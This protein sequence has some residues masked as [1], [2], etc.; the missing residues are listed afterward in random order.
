MAFE[1]SRMKLDSAR[2]DSRLSDSHRHWSAC[3]SSVKLSHA[4]SLQVRIHRC[5]VEVFGQDVRGVH[6]AV[7][8]GDDEPTCPSGLL[9]P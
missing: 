8:L 5:L 1:D 9:N 3:R 6:L 7:N 4:E 2:E